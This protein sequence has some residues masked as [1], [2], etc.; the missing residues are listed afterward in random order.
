MTGV[1]A[2]PTS[3]GAVRLHGAD[4]G[5]LALDVGAEHAAPPPRGEIEGHA[6]DIGL[7]APRALGGHLARPR[8]PPPRRGAPPAVARLRA[9]RRFPGGAVACRCGGRRRRLL[10][11]AV[12]GPPA[13]L[14]VGP[15][16][17]SR[18]RSGALT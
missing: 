18:Q 10:V 5:V 1:A 7:A 3:R 13:R 17:V 6:V 14:L 12:G 16:V 4:P 11:G 2:P 9:P 8:L 15:P